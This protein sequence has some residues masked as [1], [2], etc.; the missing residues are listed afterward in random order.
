M[1]PAVVIGQIPAPDVRA[2]VRAARLR[3]R[4]VCVAISFIALVIVPTVL[5]AW[6]LWTR[7]ADQYA[8][9]LGFSVRKEESGSAFES[10]LGIT[11]LSGSSSSDADVLFEY[12][13]S[14]DL[15][16]A[17]DNELDLVEVWSRPDPNI[18]LVFAYDPT[19]TIEDL[20]DHWRQKV[21]VSHDTSTGLIEVRVLSFDAVDS[22]AINELI[23][24]NSSL[25]IN[26]LSA[27]AREDA[28]DYARTELR[29]AET[30]LKTARID[31]LAHRNQTQIIDPSLQTLSQS[32]LIGALETQ[33]AEAQISHALLL[34]TTRAKDPRL[35][36]SERRISVIEDQI[37]K[38][39]A[40]LGLA[41]GNA[42][43]SVAAQVGEFEALSVE[44][45]FAQKAYVAAQVGLDSARNEARR[46]SRYLAA[47]V[48][49]TLAEKPEHPEREIL[50]FL[51]VVFSFLGWAIL[52]MM[53]YALW[54]RR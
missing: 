41:D 47:H 21:R 6:Y 11:Q 2:P 4:H 38:E 43:T 16:E 17:V 20:R 7:A 35:A 50:L 42:E 1:K 44:L 19:G 54:D 3:P 30:R 31:L 29:Q 46:Q 8:S 10:I 24:K 40:K 48:T 39:R 9:H 37:I 34:Q 13:Q 49:P 32:G 52:V 51:V 27:I 25:L 5:T 26:K 45:E 14:Q 15:V 36:Q 22:W 28:V 18:D 23:F 33:L 53:S 12:L